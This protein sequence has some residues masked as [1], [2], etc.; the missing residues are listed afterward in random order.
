MTE[1]FFLEKIL[2]S[3]ILLAF[4][5]FVIRLDDVF[6]LDYFCEV[7]SVFCAIWSL[8]EIK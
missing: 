2:V 7:G 4:I 1:T 5:P 8:S 3:E 6:S